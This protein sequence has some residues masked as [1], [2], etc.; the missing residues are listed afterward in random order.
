MMS[1]D[2]AGISAKTAEVLDFLE[3]HGLGYELHTHPPLPTIELALEYWKNIDSTHCKNLF[4]RNHKGNRHYL[5]VFEC[6][7]ELAIHSLEHTPYLKGSKEAFVKNVPYLLHIRKRLHNK[8]IT[9]L[10]VFCELI[11]GSRA[12][13]FRSVFSVFVGEFRT[14]VSSVRLMTGKRLFLFETCACVHLFRICVACSGVCLH[15]VVILF[16]ITNFF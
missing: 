3:K 11:T 15:S 14:S 7:K 12:F 8:F 9:E 4:F 13:L 2:K 6:H 1:A 16:S 10:D 5:V